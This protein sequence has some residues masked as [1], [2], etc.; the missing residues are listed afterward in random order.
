MPNL[1]RKTPNRVGIFAAKYPTQRAERLSDDNIVGELRGFYPDNLAI[2]EEPGDGIWKPKFSTFQGRAGKG[3][4]GVDIY[5]PYAPTPVEVPVVALRGGLLTRRSLVIEPEELGN[6]AKLEVKL[7]DGTTADIQYGHL[8]RFEGRDPPPPKTRPARPQDDPRW[9][10]EG[11]IIGYA[12]CSGNADERFECTTMSK[13]HVNAGHVHLSRVKGG[14]WDPAEK[15][16][17]NLDP[18][19]LD[20]NADRNRPAED[21]VAQN[22]G[23]DAFPPQQEP[24]PDPTQ[25]RLIVTQTPFAFRPPGGK[26]RLTAAFATIEIGDPALLLATRDFYR[27]CD[28]R[29]STDTGTATDDI[30]AFC[31]QRI[32]AAVKELRDTRKVD[33][34]AKLVAPGLAGDGTTVTVQGFEDDAVRSMFAGFALRHLARLNLMLW[35]LFGGAALDWLASN[36]QGAADESRYKARS[37]LGAYRCKTLP[38]C[39][40]G[41]APLSSKAWLSA[42]DATA[43]AITEVNTLSGWSV[44]VSFGVGSLR[45]A[46]IGSH[47]EKAVAGPLSD[48]LGALLAATNAVINVHKLVHRHSLSLSGEGSDATGIAQR[49]RF[50]AAILGKQ[51]PG[52]SDADGPGALPAIMAAADHLKRDTG[53]TMAAAFIGAAASGN[54]TLFGQLAVDAAKP[55]QPIPDTPHLMMAYTAAPP[56]TA[57][58]QIEDTAEGNNG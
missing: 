57:L 39:G 33:R 26:V 38:E 9:V 56:P 29:H 27:L 16:G 7:D 24:K 41:L 47:M 54:A 44:S 21:W 8:S 45:H 37:G 2:G 18:V 15:L 23:K 6:R 25:S 51:A 22:G 35:H 5:A 30:K 43:T 4:A 31:K 3:H 12:G 11:T 52:W 17:L 48:Y 49:K 46:T 40:I 28:L 14:D 10:D 36:A 55:D 53:E 50:V 19:A 42:C 58:R 1:I 13:A 20:G 32:E 34:I